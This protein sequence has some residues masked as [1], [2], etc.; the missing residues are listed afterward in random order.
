MRKFVIAGFVVV[1]MLLL[2][3]STAL[4]APRVVVNSQE[5]V[6]D[7][8]PVVEQGRTLVPLRAIFEA[9]GAEVS[10]DSSTQTVTATKGGT[11]IKLVIGGLAYKNGQPVELDVPARIVNDRTLVPV[12]FVSEALGARVNWDGKTQMATITSTTS[13]T[14]DTQPIGQRRP[15][16]KLDTTNLFDYELDDVSS[17]VGNALPPWYSGEYNSHQLRVTGGNPPY[18]WRYGSIEGGGP[19]SSTCQTCGVTFGPDGLVE[20]RADELPESSSY[21]IMFVKAIV[22]DSGSPPQSIDIPLRFHIINGAVIARQV[23]EQ[24]LQEV[25][26]MIRNTIADAGGLPPGASLSFSNAIIGQ[27]KKIDGPL[28]SVPTDFKLIVAVNAY[29]FSTS[30]GGYAKI[31]VVVD[32]KKKS[33]IDAKLIEYKIG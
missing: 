33:V 9:L 1:F 7:V 17:V 26:E 16:L 24:Y 15:P 8:P 2:S 20:G 11:E 6:F 19:F 13:G 32:V 29:G 14:E 27:P 31:E 23:T 10:W 18:T 28:W 4:A 25:T 3:A 5:L 22:T 12:R 30:V 21:R